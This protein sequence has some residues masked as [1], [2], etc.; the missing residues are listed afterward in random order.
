MIFS[1]LLKRHKDV[2]HR[3]LNTQVFDF[4]SEAR[5]TKKPY[6]LRSFVLTLS[7]A[8][9]RSEKVQGWTFSEIY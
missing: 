6:S 4:R 3:K 5:T 2:P 1:S 8:P 7:D 9:K